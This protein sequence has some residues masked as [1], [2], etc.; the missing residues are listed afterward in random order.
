MDLNKVPDQRTADV[1]ELRSRSAYKPDLA[2]L[3]RGQLAAARQSRG[4]S[5]DE[6]AEILEPLL[7]WPVTAAAVEAWE[8]TS[9]PPG[10]V[11]V[12][13]GLV[14]HEN[15]ATVPDSYAGDLVGQII[16]DR[17]SDVTA[18]YAT[19][20]EFVSSVPPTVLFD[21]AQDVRAAGLSLNVICQQY[22]EPKL[23]DQIEA[24]ATY[25]CTFLDPAGDAIRARE[26]EEGYPP[27]HLSALTE[28]NIQTL[29]KRVR[30][31]LSSDARDRL[32]IRTYDEVIRFNVLLIDAQTCIIQPYLPEARG[33]DSPTLVASRRWPTAGLYPIFDQIFAALWDRSRIV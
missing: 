9:V 11:L 4:L 29:V 12:A 14:T 26:I 33:V 20:S 6:F 24:G 3:A 13:A 15:P 21:D 32:E 2:G 10:D 19:R 31:K 16:G 7:G 5:P 18:I 17:F 1:V 25:R 28:L 23:R 27:G 30:D 8:T 22:S